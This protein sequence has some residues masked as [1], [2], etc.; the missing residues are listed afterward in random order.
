[1]WGYFYTPEN[2]ER[3]GA[4]QKRVDTYSSISQAGII[5]QQL[6]D[7][8]ALV[9]QKYA[10]YFYGHPT[11][12]GQHGTP[13]NRRVFIDTSQPWEDPI[14]FPDDCEYC[15]Y[16]TEERII[17]RVDGFMESVDIEILGGQATEALNLRL[18]PLYLK[19]RLCIEWNHLLRDY[20]DSNEYLSYDFE[21]RQLVLTQP[22]RKEVMDIADDDNPS[23]QPET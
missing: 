1:M 14:V 17:S 16:L 7:D 11:R 23:Y 10:G 21:K 22:P 3:A 20:V 9:A 2:A 8:W 4:Q 15:Q 12:A 6:A 19:K 13:D 5:T 18:L